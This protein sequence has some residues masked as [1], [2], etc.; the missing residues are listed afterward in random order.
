MNHFIIQESYVLGTKSGGYLDPYFKSKFF[1]NKQNIIE[2]SI[3]APVLT[4]K[5][6]AHTGIDKSIKKPVG[7]KLD[8]NGNPV[9][10]KGS[11]GQYVDVVYT[12]KISKEIT[13]KTGM[14]YGF[15]S[16]IK[17]Q[18]VFGYENPKTK[19]LHDSGH[20]Y[21]GWVM[22]SVKPNFFTSN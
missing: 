20:N 10:W 17:N 22:L 14:S 3:Y 21:F 6:K 7:Q 5:V 4:T 12:R 19:Q 8:N 2:A 9:Y 15:L 18:M 11:L 16:D 13:I 1:I